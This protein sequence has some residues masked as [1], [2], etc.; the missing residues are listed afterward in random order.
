MP[1]RESRPSANRSGTMFL[2]LIPLMPFGW[3]DYERPEAAHMF[4]TISSFGFDLD[5]DLGK[6]ATR[7]LTDSTLFKRAYFTLGGELREA[8]VVFQGVARS[9]RYDGKIYSYGLSVVGPLLWIFGLPLGSSKVSID[10][11]FELADR[12][13][14]IVWTHDF[15]GAR[16]VVQGHYYNWGTDMLAL[17]QLTQ[18]ALDSTMAS[19]DEALPSIEMKLSR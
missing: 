4:M 6:A 13:G 17:S 19:L 18:E 9:T 5:E 1:F 2:Y 3:L 10:Y 7:S 16:S 8:D 14:N 12:N 11:G 15:R